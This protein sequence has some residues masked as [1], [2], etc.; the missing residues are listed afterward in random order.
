VFIGSDC[1]I[2]NLKIN[3]CGEV[4]LGENCIFNGSQIDSFKSIKIG[5]NSLLSNCYIVDTD[6]HNIE[7][8]LRHDP[9]GEK[10]SAPIEIE[11]N[12]WIGGEAVVMKGVHIGANSVIGLGTVVRQTVPANVVVI[13]NPQ[14]VIKHLLPDREELR[15]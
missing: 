6:F 15:F 9:P 7:P 2:E 12:V 10:A 14:Q 11:S 4:T 5:N 3:G 1:H 13:G 8:Q